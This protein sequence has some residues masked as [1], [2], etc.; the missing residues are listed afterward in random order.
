MSQVDLEPGVYEVVPKVTAERVTYRK[1]VEDVVKEY[2]EKNPQKL[3]QVGMQ[4]DLAHSKGG[5]T[6]EDL[7][8]LDKEEKEKKKKEERKKKE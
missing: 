7:E 2:S 3:R 4:Y 6:D 1:V 8:L 5:I